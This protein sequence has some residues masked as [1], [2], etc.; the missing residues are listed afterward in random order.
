MVR[1]AAAGVHAPRPQLPPATLSAFH[2]ISGPATLP[3][4]PLKPLTPPSPRSPHRVRNPD[5]GRDLLKMLKSQHIG[6]ATAALY[7]E[8]A[9]L[10]LASGSQAKALGVLGKGLKE[11]AQPAG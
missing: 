10:E 2:T 3:L 8:W 7:Y 6:D 5:D 4:A 1:A 11:Q 9:A